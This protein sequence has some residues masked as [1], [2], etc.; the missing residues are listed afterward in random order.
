MVFFFSSLAWLSFF[1]LVSWLFA[2]LTRLWMHSTYIWRC[3]VK[4][5]LA[6]NNSFWWNVHTLYSC[7]IRF[8]IGFHFTRSFHFVGVSNLKKKK[9]KKTKHWKSTTIATNTEDEKKKKQNVNGKYRKRWWKE[10]Q[11]TYC[12]SSFVFFR[13]GRNFFLIFFFSVFFTFKANL[14]YVID[15]P[16]LWFSY[17]TER[18]RAHTRALH[19]IRTL[20]IN[21]TCKCSIHNTHNTW[22]HCCNMMD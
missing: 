5:L 6:I 7:F 15:P 10:N 8:S 12:G 21:L 2:H 19:K 18:T 11:Q 17:L 22:T 9:R 4:V 3:S 14:C 16:I 20:S 13:F 1:F